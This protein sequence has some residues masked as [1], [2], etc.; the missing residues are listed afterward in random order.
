MPYS[1][2]VFPVQILPHQCF[3]GTELRASSATERRSGSAE[4]L[5]SYMKWQGQA[6]KVFY[7]S[8]KKRTT[9]EVT[10]ALADL[11]LS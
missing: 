9:A 1:T 4:P 7:F 2:W 11:T 10:P 6:L 8:F 5:C 3:M